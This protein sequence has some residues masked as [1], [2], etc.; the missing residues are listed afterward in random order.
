[1]NNRR[2]LV[3]ALGAGAFTAPFAS[4]AQ[5]PGKVWRIGILEPV[6]IEL[7]VANMDGF[8]QGMR[9]QSYVEGKDYAIEY[10]SFDGR[11]DKLSA[12][13]T[14]LIRR[15][16]DLIMTRGTPAVV[17]AKNATQTLP[18]VTSA[19]GDPIGTGIVSSLRRPGGNIT[20]LSSLSSDTGS[21]RV[22]LI[23]DLIP[24][25]KS[26]GVLHNAANPATKTELDALQVAATH[27]K[28]RLDIIEVLK[29]EDFES[30]FASARKHHVDALIVEADGL[31]QSN[32][33]RV[34]GLANLYRLPVVY[35]FGEFV[36]AGGLM[37]YGVNYPDLYRRAAVY[38][39][40]I[41][42]GAKPGDLPVEQPTKFDMVIN[43]KT[44]KTLGIKIPNSILVQAT[45]VIE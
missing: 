7:S 34:V 2:K 13:I 26:L 24:R 19:M 20:G 42:K 3:I 41:F 22:Q 27:F 36:D 45:K 9:E 18:I 4:F 32:I 1:V 8:R 17:A 14:D 5:Q 29:S 21:K 39:D 30:A 10:R 38:I 31:M 11:S 28:L 44:A 43:L 16:V 25:A 15:N 40:K 6:S 37:V 33:K 35:P 23:K 12:A